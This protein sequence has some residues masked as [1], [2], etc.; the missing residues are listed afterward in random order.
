MSEPDADLDPFEAVAESFLARFRAGQRPS[1][2]E[3]A[4]RHPDLAEELRELL[5]AMVMV[6]QDLTIDPDL[7]SFDA[8]PALIHPSGKERRLGDYHILREIG[9]GGMGLVYEAE[10]VSLGRRVALKVLPGHIAGDT[11]A[12]QRFQHE[13][14]AAARLHHTNIVPVFDVGRD[15]EVAYYAMQF[16]Q[17]QGLDRVIDELARL[18]DPKGKLDRAVGTGPTAIGARAPALSRVAEALLSGRF[19]TEV[20]ARSS[21]IPQ[22]AAAVPTATEPRAV[23]AAR[24]SGSFLADLEPPGPEPT[25]APRHS[26]VLPGGNLVSAAC[27]SGRRAPFFRSVAQIGHQAAQGLA[28]AHASGV[29][30]RDIKPSNLL[31][32]HAGVV[33]ITDFGLAKG[34]DEGLTHT[35]DIL[36]TLRYMGP[37]RFRGE[38]DARADVYALGLTLYELLTLHTGFDSSDRLNL[39][40]QIKTEEP[41]KPRSLDGHIP[42]DLETIVLKAI[43][44]EPKARYQS[45]AAMG[46]DLRRFLADE[47]IVARRASPPERLIRWSRRHRGLAA[48]LA[49]TALLLLVATVVSGL[50]AIR[51]QKLAQ[52][53]D[54][55]RSRAWTAQ[56]EA[57]GARALAQVQGEANR[58]G[59]Y[60]AQMNLAGQ[61]TALPG[62]LAR[63]TELLDRWRLDPSPSDLRNWEWYY[64]DA[65]T[66]RDQL[67]LRGHSHI[68]EAVRWSPDGTRLATAGKDKFI[69]I[70]N[71][72]S[73]RE[74]ATWHP[75]G[76][77]VQDLDWSPDGTRLVSG[78]GDASVRVWDAHLGREERTLKGHT[79][80]VF[81]VRWN[82]DG[83][84]LASCGEDGTVRIWDP[85]ARKAPLVL[86]SQGGWSLS[87]A[88]SPDGSHL[89]SS[90]FDKTVKVW[91]ATTGRRVRDLIG[92]GRDL[93]RVRWSHDGSRIACGDQGGM[94]WVW[95]ASDGQ[96]VRNWVSGKFAVMP[97]AWHPQDRL[98]ASGSYDGSVRV[99]DTTNG[100]ETRCLAGHTDEVHE[101]CWSPDGKRLASA[102]SDHTVRVWDADQA[103]EA[104]TWAA[105][106]SEVW[107]VAWSPDGLRLASGATEANVR[108]W[109]GADALTPA[110]LKG[111]YDE[112]RALSWSPDGNRLATAGGAIWDVATDKVALHLHGKTG[113]VMATCWSPDG[114]KLATASRDHAVRI[115]DARSGETLHVL[116]TPN[117]WV[118]SVAW[119]P[120]GTRLA[121]SGDNHAIQI[122]DA[123][124][125]DELKTLHGHNHVVNT[126]RWS[127]DGA[128][129]ASSS[130]DRTVRVWDVAAGAEALILRGHTAVVCAVCWS[131]D[132]SR[133]ASVSADGTARIWDASDGGEAFTL[134]GNAN[135]LWSV[136]WS[137][138]GTRLAAGD[139]FGNVLV[140]SA[141]A[142]IHRECSPRLLA[143]LDSRIARNPTAARDRALR[144]AVLSRLGD[145]DLAATDF[146]AAGHA[147]PDAPQWFQPG[148]WLAPAQA[149]DEPGSALSLLARFEATTGVGPRSDPAAPRWLA[150]ATDPNGFLPPSG[151]RG[152]LYATRIYSLR[153]QDVILR[154][155]EGARPQLWLNGTLIAPGAP[156]PAD[157]VEKERDKVPF[158]TSLRA[159][160]NTLLVR[161]SREMEPH[162][163]SLLVEPARKDTQVMARAPAD[164]GD[165]ERGFETLDRHDRMENQKRRA[166]EIAVHRRRAE[167]F[168]RRAQWS[169][170]IAEMNRAIE[171]DPDEHETWYFLAPLFVEARDGAAYDRHRRAMLDRWHNTDDPRL[172]ERTAKACLL[173][174]GLPD[175]IRPAAGLAGLALDRGAAGRGHFIRTCS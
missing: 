101:L 88:W 40:E 37:E 158:A 45:A 107:S 9:R 123:V 27:L 6:E 53:K 92:R 109:S 152:T 138:D 78:Q 110:I 161:P 126:V 148:W 50:A 173:L 87:V 5:P 80:P 106:S 125:G 70:W 136:D 19:V 159:G 63:V 60:F 144:G 34:E 121:S 90:H 95:D 105:H 104:N 118:W 94:I 165:W 129:L 22:A 52:E 62:G 57:E 85:A 112:G 83:T 41:P 108:L 140:W 33:W 114:T 160:W 166:L 18:R 36:G 66:C 69:K 56:K 7:G 23:G 84:R 21:H 96:V 3:Y 162:F 124:T 169:E 46:E 81:G 38:G 149:E 163:L 48:S 97:L 51:F 139:K 71:A 141:I 26:A 167:D 59:L 16:I 142:A 154:V 174:P 32:D 12:M 89:A 122:W 2:E 145:W 82:P 65:L 73:G 100:K 172:A 135:P 102:G 54:V 128:R 15:G 75:R 168:V 39:I 170:A 155:G 74:I 4:A 72:V 93:G 8:R 58:R 28:Y 143:W 175:V 98:L 24:T 164:R 119:S 11:D 99:W 79:G 113:G 153:E 103:G 115:W 68:I 157:E 133:I 17:G 120:D 151:T 130:S 1:I 134:Q 49:A 44:K 76:Q 30:H 61:A 150:G 13:A 86:T 31:L 156:A 127:P 25:T 43:E 132:G 77:E 111:Q 117:D 42:R 147:S 116:H 137:P 29:V 55:E 67:T 47:P 10:Q 14:R 64:L 91:D 20:A 131:P 146:D 35:G 171:L